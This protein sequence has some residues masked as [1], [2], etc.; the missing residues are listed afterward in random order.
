MLYRWPQGRVIRT[1]CAV[2]VVIIAV[3]MLSEAWG[4]YSAW[5]ASRIESSDPVGPG[6]LIHAAVFGLL[7]LGVAVYGLLAVGFLKRP[8]QFLIEVEGEMTRVT[9]PKRN[10]VVRATIIIGIMTV[11]MAFLLFLIDSFNIYVVH[12]RLMGLEV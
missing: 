12:Q 1:I 10:E 9:W 2:L 8:A 4:T 7:G 3:D 5:D 6:L 11:V